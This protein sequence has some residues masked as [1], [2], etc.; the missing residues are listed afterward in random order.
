MTRAVC[1]VS[2]PADWY[3]A[4]S[5]CTGYGSGVDATAAAGG[6]GAG[7]AGGS[8]HDRKP[9]QSAGGGTGGAGG[10]A[11]GAGW[12]CALGVQPSCAA[13]GTQIIATSSMSIS[14]WMPVSATGLAASTV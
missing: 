2:S 8:A 7:G 10:A 4:G 11:G 12:T 3:E 9:D 5:S 13:S 6:G 14:E 1:T